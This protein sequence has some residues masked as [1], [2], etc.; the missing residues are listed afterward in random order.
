MTA[1]HAIEV[2]GLLRV[3]LGVCEFEINKPARRI[4]QIADKRLEERLLSRVPAWVGGPL[5]YDD[6]ANIVADFTDHEGD[7]M[8]V[9]VI[10][11]VITREGAD[12]YRF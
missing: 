11:G 8:I 2:E 9:R 5:F 4:I 7:T 3:G 10:S 12:E 6:P 1:T